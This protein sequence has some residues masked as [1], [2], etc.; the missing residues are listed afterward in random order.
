MPQTADTQ[1][2]IDN[3]HVA[4]PEP[5]QR[6][7]PQPEP[8]QT[9]PSTLG[10]TPHEPTVRPWELELLISGAL[11]FSLMQ[12]PG[13]VDAWF[14]ATAPQL[15]GGGY[16]A[17]FMGWFYVK[18]ALYALVGGFV[19]H[20]SVR[21]YWVGVIGIEA[22][23]PHGIRWDRTR[24]GPIFRQ[25]QC[26]RT[27]SLQSLIDGADRFASMV[28]GATFAGAMF[29]G[30]SLVMA[31]LMIGLSF[32][33]GLVV[34]G[35][36]GGSLA[37]NLICLLIAL[38]GVVASVVDRRM[39]DR[40]DP[41]GR[42]ARI[43]RRVALAYGRVSGMALFM[44]LVLTLVTNLYERRR[45]VVMIVLIP[46]AFMTFFF[47][48]DVMLGRGM[49]QADGYAFLPD[50]AGVLAVEPA[51]YADQRAGEP[52]DVSLPQIQSSMVRDP[53][54]RLFIPYRPRRHNDLIARDCPGVNAREAQAGTRSEAVLHCLSSLQPV[55][56]NGR[57]LAPSFRFYTLPQTGIRGI[58][59][60]IP[61]T[62]LPKGENVLTVAK[63]PLI[64]DRQAEAAE[65][66]KPEP[67]HTIPF[68]L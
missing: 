3:L 54:V 53:Y 29:F 45:G 58:V 12:L 20:L 7:T 23:F 11:V 55:A 22:V 35:A 16:L 18:M 44:P 13:Q 41:G 33:V 43:I 14:N 17:A 25:V 56:L 1:I 8:A 24:S 26:E 65:P 62:G 42:P 46:A 30:F 63:L 38:P 21:G 19:L 2:A 39:G 28:F 50:K 6:E 40:L 51:F 66:A 5:P 9:V 31:A 59:A 48:K 57:A 36:A 10:Q 15:A 49:I 52:G 34:P 47:V 67:P 64:S 68:G 60:Y 61:V 37:L 4:D 32:L 27:P